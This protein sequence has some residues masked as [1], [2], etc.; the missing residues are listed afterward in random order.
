MARN[1]PLILLY[2]CL[3]SLSLFS[4]TSAPDHQLLWRISGNGLQADSYLYGT[5]HVRDKQAFDFSDSVL[6]KLESCAAFALEIHPDSVVRNMLSAMIRQEEETRSIKEL[7]DEETFKELNE[8]FQAETGQSLEGMSADEVWRIEKLL[9]E[10]RKKEDAEPVFLDAFLYQLSRKLGKKIIGLET[11]EEHMAGDQLTNMREDRVRAQLTKLLKP[12]V[13]E[14]NMN[15]M[16]EMYHKGDLKKVEL[17]TTLT[18]FWDTSYYNALIVKRNKTMSIRIQDAVQAQS[19]FIAVGVAHLPGEIGLIQLLQEEGYEVTPVPAIF[20]GMAAKYKPSEVQIPWYTFTPKE[21]TFRIDMP[22]EPVPYEGLEQDGGLYLT[23]DI[24]SGIAYYAA[25]FAT[26]LQVPEDKLDE[27]YDAMIENMTSSKGKFAMEKKLRDKKVTYQGVVGKEVLLAGA[28]N[29]SFRIRIFAHQGFVRFFMAGPTKKLATSRDADR[30]FES[31][32][33]QKA[34]ERGWANLMVKQAGFSIR[35]PEKYQKNQETMDREDPSDPRPATQYVYQGNMPKENQLFIASYLDFPSGIS[36]QEDDTTYQ[37]GFTDNILATMEG[38]VTG[39][40][41]VVVDGY[42]GIERT[43]ESKSNS[44]T[45]RI[46]LFM[47]NSRAYILMAFYGLGI[48]EPVEVKDFFDSFRILPAPPI[49]WQSYATPDSG[50]QVLLPEAPYVEIDTNYISY[51]GYENL[52]YIH[53]YFAMDSLSAISFSLSEEQYDEFWEIEH[54]DSLLEATIENYYYSY[55]TLLE[56]RFFDVDGYRGVEFVGDQAGRSSKDR[57]K[58]MVK[59]NSVYTLFCSLYS[60]DLFSHDVNRFFESID[61]TGKPAIGDPLTDK[62]KP[63]IDALAASDSLTRRRAIASLDSYL[64]DSSH[65]ALICQALTRSYAD[66]DSADVASIYEELLEQL[67]EVMEPDSLM[68]FL[69]THKNQFPPYPIVTREVMHLFANTKTENGALELR[70]ML[71]QHPEAITESYNLYYIFSPI[72]DSIAL[73]THLFPSLFE[74]LPE[75]KLRS[76]IID[77]A[78][79]AHEAKVIDL[80]QSPDFITQ[81]TA[82]GQDALMHPDMLTKAY[83]D[84]ATLLSQVARVLPYFPPT[85]AR[86]D[87]LNHLTKS[88]GYY[89]KNN[90]FKGLITTGESVDKKMLKEFMADPEGRIGVMKAILKADRKKLISKKYWKQEAVARRLLE[91]N[92]A[93]DGDV[94]YG[95]KLLG[96]FKVRLNDEEGILYAYQAKWADDMEWS[97][98]LSGLQPLDEGQINLD[99]SFFRYYFETFESAADLKAQVKESL[100]DDSDQVEFLD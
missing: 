63:I 50:I 78:V 46:Q 62:S 38:E 87:I 79:E 52:K 24:G 22:Y 89:V 88:E 94:F 70:K 41:N 58:I 60:K 82:Y 9:G 25:S 18:Q 34:P 42:L 53:S 86:S 14:R 15:Q 37:N 85:K 29:L 66:I 67:D 28:N 72:E 40:K 97:L 31:L 1:I 3:H 96:S 83:G 6:L 19:T 11:M 51:Y 30:F 99:A 100:E 16:L 68:D 84:T 43:L 35:F 61:F 10:G 98:C 55:D 39:K 5:M 95:L 32:V 45:A 57:I 23:L 17:L 13:R 91:A 74:L 69:L 36:V 81:V 92:N 21:G 4:Q 54:P 75:Q 2:L 76:R 12:E 7:Y 47:R 20:T 73:A 49:T 8:Y 48:E 44:L 33:F 64:M 90:A 65:Q 77:L 80:S 26:E 56:K 59:G 27:V 71:L 93:G